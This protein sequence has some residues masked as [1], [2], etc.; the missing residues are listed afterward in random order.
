MRPGPA[1]EVLIELLVSQAKAERAR[2]RAESDKNCIRLGQ[3]QAKRRGHDFVDTWVE[4]QGFRDV[5]VLM[6]QLRDKKDALE[7]QRKALLK[8]RPPAPAPAPSQ[9]TQG[10]AQG[11]ASLLDP[12]AVEYA[13]NEEI[14]KL[15]VAQLK[16]EEADLVEMIGALERDRNV[17]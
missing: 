5:H 6:G 9:S 7:A 1:G 12:A 2:C 16:K 17:V 4:G 14:L 15:R 8:T 10:A 3:F 13:H 11:A